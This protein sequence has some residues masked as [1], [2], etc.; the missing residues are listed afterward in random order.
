MDNL[1][2]LTN[3]DEISDNEII[4][5]NTKP[6]IKEEETPKQIFKET[7][8]DLEIKEV[9]EV[10]EDDKP[11]ENPV[12]IAPIKKKKQTRNYTMTPARKI[13]VEKMMAGKKAKKEERDKLRKIENDKKEELKLLKEKEKQKMTDELNS[14][15]EK[16]G[17]VELK[18]KPKKKPQ[19]IIEENN[20]DSDTDDDISDKDYKKFLKYYAKAEQL[21]QKRKS[22]KQREDQI[23]KDRIE[24]E[25]YRTASKKT[26]KE[27]ESLKETQTKSIKKQYQKPID[28]LKQN[29]EKDEYYNYFN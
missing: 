2:I 26:L 1:P 19:V 10:A 27:P 6:E 21:K 17:D 14:L 29:E 9:V 28:I 8:P 20:D 22:R 18:P 13:A 4:D 11:V 16:V 3:E 15:R 25:N 7:K 23:L 24:L 5:K 12:E